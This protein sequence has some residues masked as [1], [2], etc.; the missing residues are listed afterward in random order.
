MKKIIFALILSGVTLVSCSKDESIETT[1]P[2]TSSFSISNPNETVNEQQALVI[3]NNSVNAVSYLWDF[4]NGVTSTEKVPTYSYPMCGNYNLKLTV[5]DASGK[6]T[7]S[8]KELPV[9]CVFGGHHT[10]NTST[11]K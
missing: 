7:V 11:G 1:T 10:P 9:L 2:A 3:Q 5:T 8:T 4:G 6:Q